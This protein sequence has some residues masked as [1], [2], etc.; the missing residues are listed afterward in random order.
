MAV[1]ENGQRV[2][3]RI[4]GGRRDVARRRAAAGATEAFHHLPAVVAATGSSRRLEVH[5]LVG[6]LPHVGDQEVTGGPIEGE[7]PR[8]ADA[9]RPR[10]RQPD[11]AGVRRRDPIV[12][13]DVEVLVHVDAQ[14][15]AEEGVVV[16]RVAGGIVARAAVPGP[17]VEVVIGTELELATVVVRVR[18]VRDRLQDD[19]GARVGQ[20]GVARLHA[21]AR[22]DDGAVPGTRVV[23]VEVRRRREVRVEGDAQQTLLAARDDERADVEERR[24]Q[25]HAAVVDQHLTVLQSEEEAPGAVVSVGDRVDGT[26]ARGDALHGDRR[27][28]GRGSAR[29][30]GPEDDET[31]DNRGRTRGEGHEKKYRPPRYAPRVTERNCRGGLSRP[32]LRPTSLPARSGTSPAGRRPG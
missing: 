19:G 6:A 1:V 10:L 5:L 18:R 26:Q 7:T 21:I 9:L 23:D 29:M 17:D 24:R 28:L 25:E 12:G 14:D 30:R 16:L 13:G 27:G 32:A 20:V 15:P 11:G 8:V 22:D 3:R 31:H 4:A 2:A